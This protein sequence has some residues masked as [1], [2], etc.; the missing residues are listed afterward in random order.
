MRL[1]ATN[2][3]AIVLG[4]FLLTVPLLSYAWFIFI[5]FGAIQKAMETDPDTI[6]ASASDRV[7]GKCSGYHVN[8]ARKFTTA[9]STF[10]GEA[11]APQ[12]DSP[13][14]L[15]HKKMAEA[16]LAK[17]TEG[18]VVADL[19]SAYS[20][21]WSRVAGA[22][23]NANLAYG[24]DLARGCIQYDIPIRVVDYAAW[25]A[26]QEDSRRKVAEEEARRLAE[27]KQKK[28]AADTEAKRANV[29][30]APA[31]DGA[32]QIASTS[33]SD[34]AA[35]ARKSA[36]V[37]SCA[38]QDLREIGADGSNVLFLAACDSGQTLVL[39]CDPGGLCLKR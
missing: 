24:A 26:R 29:A 35:E 22:D 18:R 32:A 8:Q 13:E 30:A 4:A 14:S 11:T 12:R 19:A 2:S 34:L 28:L 20:T 21:R 36:R 25:E 7:L 27:E 31:G 1:K 6:A 5:P 37:L 9:S 16:A 33:T 15:F 38:A 23:M 3:F 17:G 10:P 39:T